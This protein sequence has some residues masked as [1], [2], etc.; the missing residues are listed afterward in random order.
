MDATTQALVADLITGRIVGNW[1]FWLM[2]FL[3]SAAA[4]I[5]ASYLK[6]Y[7]TKKGEQLATKEDFEILKTQLQ[8]TT[9]ITEEIK[10][11]VGHIEWR[12]REMYS[13]R[14]TKL[15]EFVQQIGT[16]TSM[17]DPW[18]SDMQTGTFG[19]L[20]SECLNR[21]EMLARLYFPPLFAPTMGFTLA[22]RSLIQQALAAGQALGR[23]DQGDLQARQKQMDENLS[24]FKPLHVEML[25]RRSA[26][27]E[28]VVTVMQ[29]VLRLPDEPPRAP[30]GTE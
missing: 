4:T 5:A 15:E 7:G 18:V 27:E 14:R 20:D 23:I 26:L 16:V 10:N 3:V 19:S 30:R 29:D 1:M 12:T 9:R 22:W 2:V 11:E 8:A 28:T 13:T 24:T 17:L 25:V 6:G 21:L